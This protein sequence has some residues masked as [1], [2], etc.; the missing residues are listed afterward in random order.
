M[1]YRSI[2]VP[3]HTHDS[4]RTVKERLAERLYEER[5]STKL[6][7]TDEITTLDD[8]V[9]PAPQQ[10]AHGSRVKSGWEYWAKAL[11]GVLLLSVTLPH[12]PGSLSWS[13]VVIDQ[14][15]TASV[16]WAVQAAAGSFLLVLL[17]LLCGCVW[18]LRYNLC[19]KQLIRENTELEGRRKKKLLELFGHDEAT[20]VVRTNSGYPTRSLSTLKLV[21]FGDQLD[22]NSTVGRCGVNSECTNSKGD[23]HRIGEVCEKCKMTIGSEEDGLSDQA[24]VA[25]LVYS[26]QDGSAN[27]T[28]PES[29]Q[30]TE[31][32]SRKRISV[33]LP[34][35]V[36]DALKSA[37]LYA[38]QTDY[39]KSVKNHR[40]HDMLLWCCA[41]V[42]EP[43]AKVFW[44]RSRRPVYAALVV[45]A[46][47]GGLAQAH[48]E[49]GIIESSTDENYPKK[50][51]ELA[52]TFRAY[53]DEMIAHTTNDE[54]SRLLGNGWT[55]GRRDSDDAL[56]K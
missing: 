22:E 48:G 40:D 50:L 11:V 47:C 32:G 1:N 51:K 7:I 31:P 6:A 9:F 34:T 38:E 19:S 52:K 37:G 8:M 41:I 17:C 54:N 21:R 30:T 13:V 56:A 49:S 20:D 12:V 3:C 53:A 10:A 26:G 4:L 35:D 16:Q 18:Y 36:K 24:R 55:E 45:S 42:D 23:Q 14:E 5:D 29:G 2:T 25:F 44:E 28:A 46:V 33:N 43:L 39:A 27:Q 15:N